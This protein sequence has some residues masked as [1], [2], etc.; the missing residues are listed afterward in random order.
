VAEEGTG[1]PK[2][3]GDEALECVSPKRE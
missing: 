3:L 1:T 2:E